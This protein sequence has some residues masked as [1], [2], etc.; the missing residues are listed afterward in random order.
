[1]SLRRID[2]EQL[3][4]TPW[5]NGGGST[6]QLAIFPETAGLDDFAWR[7][8]CARMERD[9]PFSAFPGIDRSLALLA[10]AGLRLHRGS[11]TIPLQ[12]CTAPLSFAGEEVIEAELADRGIL[13]LNLMT[14][15]D[16]WRHQLQHLHLQGELVLTDDA[17]VML[18]WCNGGHLDCR[19]QDGTRERLEQGQGL[20]RQG[21]PQR[22]QLT[23]SACCYLG[24]IF[25]A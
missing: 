8:S 4:A 6:R 21:P 3:P 19:L 11:G 2:L 12:P 18:I 5:K 9:G 13:D 7:I 17:P 24:R 22:L 23:G 25:P 10:G 1:M 16:G 14:R 20:L 15:R